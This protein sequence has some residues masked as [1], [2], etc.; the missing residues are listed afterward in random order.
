M[1]APTVMSGVIGLSFGAGVLV[2]HRAV[3]ARPTSIGVS[4]RR[5]DDRGTSVTGL[6]HGSYS[7][8][9]SV[10]RLTTRHMRRGVADDLAV[11]GRTPEQHGIEKIVCAFALAVIPVG[12]VGVLH[13]G[14]IGLPVGVAVIGSPLGCA[15]GYLVPDIT[16]RSRAAD[17]RRAF[18]F[19]L[20]AYLDLV[21]VLLAG[22]AGI[23]TA[24]LAAAEAGDGWAF[25][26]IR[27]AIV[28]SRSTRTSPWTALAEL[29]Q[30]LGVSDLVELAANVELAGEQGARIRRSLVAK[31]EALRGRHAA[32]VEAAANAATERMGLPTVVMFLGFLVLL[33]YPATVTVM[34]GIGG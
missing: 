5:L 29:G 20:S 17:R 33:G 13:M 9:R 16:L 23:E 34:G 25:E 31:A 12:L 21:N 11:A 27:D 4:L 32:E 18:R 14:G 2:L 10:A 26:H 7:H 15:V 24:L 19:A 3:V 22:G 8:R 28:R 6:G 1:T 30:G